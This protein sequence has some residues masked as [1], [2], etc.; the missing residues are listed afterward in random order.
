M[1]PQ[2]TSNL[3]IKHLQMQTYNIH[4]QHIYKHSQTFIQHRIHAGKTASVYIKMANAYIY[5]V[6]LSMACEK[7][8][9]PSSALYSQILSISTN[10]LL[11]NEI[12]NFFLPKGALQ[13][14]PSNLPTLFNYI[15]WV[16]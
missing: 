5:K 13:A 6:F 9:A 2:K 14:L 11:Q 16:L 10:S 1:K 4:L 7:V 8:S 3:E 15:E 12:L